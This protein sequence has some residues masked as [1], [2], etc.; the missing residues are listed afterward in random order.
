M[1]AKIDIEKKDEFYIARC[2][3][4]ALKGKGYVSPNPMVG[5]VIVKD[6]KIIGEGYHEKYGE[7]HAEVNAIKNATESV[8]GATLY[9]NLEPC[10]HYG[11]TPP[12]VDL[13]IESKIKRV[14]ISTIDPNP[15]VNG[16]GIEKLKN[17]GIEVTVGVLEEDAKKLNEF[18]FKYITQGIPF[19]G[20]KIAQTIDAK[21]ADIEGNSK[22]ITNEQSLHY[23]H[24]LRHEYDAV[25]IGSRTAKL[26]NPNLTVR[27]VE[28]RNPYRIVLDST[29]SLPFELNIF[30]DNNKD[31]TIVF[32]SA[33]SFREKKEKIEKLD[34]L[35]IKV[36]PVK[37]SRKKLDLKEVLENLAQL[38]I[39]SVLVEGGGKIF[40]EF[41]K[42]KLADKVYV[43]IA[44]KILGKG[45]QSIG[46]IGIKSIKE[47]ITLKDISI[48]NFGDDVLITGYLR[49]D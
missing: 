4:L 35:G 44:P 39:A 25:L 9:V 45:I 24:Q 37:S 23:V 49:T 6:N 29:L 38:E 34:S 32:T 2:F 10:V 28:G 18:F 36:I 47:I 26:D 11:K 14:V 19:V 3:Q 41:L 46:D 40:T 30:S 15:L 12:C 1:P 31:K 7:A 16:K 48:Q 22:W 21:I 8:E 17:A 20:L 5:C 43:F 13:I 42:R 27:L 33:E